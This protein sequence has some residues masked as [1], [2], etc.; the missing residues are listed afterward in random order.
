MTAYQVLP[1]LSAED[2]AALRADIAARGVLV[3]V[4]YDEN[5]NILDGH[6]RVR[7]CEELG[8]TDW[9]RFIRKGLSEADKRVHARQLNLA[10]RHLSRDQKR[11]LIAAQLRETPEK[12]NR[13]VAEGLGVDHKTVAAVREVAARRGEI[14][15]VTS[16]T[17]T[18]G[19]S[20][21]ARKPIR[22]TFVD[23]DAEAAEPGLVARAL[24]DMLERGEEP[25]NAALRREVV[26]PHVAHNT[27]KVE[28]YTPGHIL[29]AARAVLGGFDLDPA[30]SPAA[31]EAVRAARIFTAE[32]DGLAQEWPVGR[33]WMNPPYASGL[34]DRFALRFC[35]AIRDGS[36]GVVLVNNA[37]E[38]GW[39]QELLGV[40]DAVCFPRGRV[41][42]V[43]PG[44]GEAGAP[45]QGQAIIY[46]GP[47]PGD[48][49][50]AFCER[51]TVL[52]PLR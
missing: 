13:Q 48:F 25:T 30:S 52:C 6:H 32:D 47:R 3:P 39:F 29:D 8:L 43:D 27:G 10:R 4:E 9:P 51:G 5:G 49:R 50:A 40:A 46:C 41:R 2:F 21:P 19:R 17:D 28:W 23:P 7:A 42:F 1:D 31:N 11:D 14:P 20:Q 36:S 38:T 26:K 45:L 12:S 16:T 37:T 34:V 15:H 35:Q 24:D 22:T 18:L 33:I 44:K